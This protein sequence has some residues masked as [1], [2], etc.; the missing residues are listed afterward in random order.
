M[1]N[2]FKVAKTLIICFCVIFLEVNVQAHEDLTMEQ[3]NCLVDVANSSPNTKALISNSRNRVLS[4]ERQN[5]YCFDFLSRIDTSGNIPPQLTGHISNFINELFSVHFSA[6]F[7]LSHKLAEIIALAFPTEVL[8]TYGE[9]WN[10][11]VLTKSFMEMNFKKEIFE[12]GYKCVQSQGF[13]TSGD[14]VQKLSYLKDVVK[15]TQEKIRTKLSNF[16]T[17]L[18]FMIDAYKIWLTTKD[19]LSK[20]Y[21]SKIP[22][23]PR[24]M[25]LEELREYLDKE[26]L[27]DKHK[28]IL[29]TINSIT[30]KDFYQKNSSFLNNNF[31]GRSNYDSLKKLFI[32]LIHTNLKSYNESYFVKDACNKAIEYTKIKSINEKDKF[33]EN[34]TNSLGITSNNVFLI[35]KTNYLTYMR[36]MFHETVMNWQTK[37][38]DKS[39]KVTNDQ[40]NLAEDLKQ[41]YLSFFDFGYYKKYNRKLSESIRFGLYYWFDVHLD[42]KDQI[43]ELLKPNILALNGYYLGTAEQGTAGQKFLDILSNGPNSKNLPIHELMT[44]AKIKTCTNFAKKGCIAHANFH[45]DLVLKKNCKKINFKD[46]KYENSLKKLWKSK[47][48]VFSDSCTSIGKYL[49]INGINYIGDISTIYQT[50]EEISRTLANDQFG[51]FGE[52]QFEEDSSFLTNLCKFPK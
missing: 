11:R 24:L 43:L 9:D 39:G 52:E 27:E 3:V 8:Y 12:L 23:M 29:E 35:V 28:M 49:A 37:N 34:F 36:K 14:A 18:D 51:I 33:C 1:G 46:K 13:M 48:I 40:Q 47:Y 38:N 16:K 45:S 20:N 42:K 50:I 17:E 41:I 26:Q 25:F 15:L 2:N 44:S 30:W 32:E 31:L 5:Y 7:G 22:L 6:V 21:L 4:V 19:N 10:A